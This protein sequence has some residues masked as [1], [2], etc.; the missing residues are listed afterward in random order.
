[1]GGSTVGFALARLGRRVLFLEKRLFLCGGA[2]RGDGRLRPD[3]EDSPE[4]RLRRG[5][6][7]YPIVGSTDAGRLESFGAQGC[8][9][10]GT[11]SV[12]AAQLER[13]NPADFTPRAHYADVPDTTLPEAWPITY[14]D[15]LPYYR[16]AEALYRVRGTDDPLNPDP[17]SPLLEPPPMSER[18]QALFD[19]LGQLGLHLY[20]AHVGCEFVEGYEQCGG[21]ICPRDCKNDA[22]RSC[23]MPALRQYGARILDQCEVLRLESSGRAVQKVY[24]R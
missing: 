15:L 24:C 8:G 6:W 1:M 17:S 14:E 4:A 5:W 13:F 21:V 16:E 10:G 12:Y 2:D 22:G 9:S 7:P 11:S 23:L 19:S 20:W 18:D 3:A